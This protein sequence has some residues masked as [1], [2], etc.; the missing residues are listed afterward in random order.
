MCCGGRGFPKCILKKIE[1]LGRFDLEAAFVLPQLRVSSCMQ[2][3]WWLQCR[4]PAIV[5]IPA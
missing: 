2:C 3:D 5:L 1:V 4:E